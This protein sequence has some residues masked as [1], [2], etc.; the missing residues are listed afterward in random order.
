VEGKE[1]LVLRKIDYLQ[2]VKIFQVNYVFSALISLL[3]LTHM[4]SMILREKSK[5]QVNARVAISI[6]DS[7]VSLWLSHLS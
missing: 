5:G 3:Q 4:A 2:A 7:W 1:K 6:M